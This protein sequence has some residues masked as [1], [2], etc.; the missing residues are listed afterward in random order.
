MGFSIRGYVLEPPRVG[1]SNSPFTSS[2]ANFIS[3]PVAFGIAYP[4]TEA[5]PRADY[6]TLVTN[7][8]VGGLLRN[9]SFGWTKNEVVR[10]FDYASR[11][12]RFKPL[13]G[14]TI[15]TAG[16]I[17]PNSNTQRLK[18]VPAPLQALAD[19]P[20]RLSI[21]TVGSGNTQ[22][23]V[24][25][26]NDG[27][28]GAPPAGTTELSLATGNLNWNP[29]DLVAYDGQ[30]LRY[31]QQAYFDYDKS[32]GD[33]GLIN[34]PVL[35]LNPIP[36]TGQFPLIRI[37]FSLYLTPIERP[38]EAGFSPDPAAGTVE[39]ALN[40]GRLKFHSADIAAHLGFPIYYDGTL[41][42]I[43]LQLP[44]Q[45]IGLIDAPTPIV[46]LPPD[47]GD[48]IFDLPSHVPY[49][50]FAQVVRT[51]TF[52][53]VGKA[54]E[55]QVN[56]GTGAVQFSVSDRAIYTGSPVE[57]V[58]GDLVID[59]GVS[60]RLFRTPVNLDASSTTKDVTTIY[61]VQN[62]VWASP[63]I[64]SPQVFLPS[65]PIDALAYPL[66]VS[67]VQGTGSFTGTLNRLDVPGPPPGLGYF[68]DFDA[69]T[70]HYAQRKNQTLI[71]LLQSS[72]TV[73]LPD[74]L[75]LPGN[76][77]LELETGTGTGIYNPLTIGTDVLL[78]PTPGLATFTTTQGLTIATGATASFSGLTFTDAAG[79][80][81]AAGVQP[82]DFI[83]ISSSAAK[84]VYTVAA[85][86]SPTQLT[87]DVVAQ[88]PS[89]TGPPAPV[90][91]T[92][93]AYT[94]ERGKEILADRFFQEVVLIDPSTMLER[95]RGIGVIQNAT[96]IVA[97]QNATFPDFLTLSDPL[98]NF[99]TSGV[100][101]GDTILLNSGP[102]TGTTRT[103]TFVEQ[104]KLTVASNL[105]FAF[106]T[107]ATYS[108]TRRLRIP[109]SSIGTSRFRFGLNT[110]STSVNPVPNDS[111]FTNPVT[112][113]SGIVE[114]SQVTGNLNFSNA[115]IV[116]ALQIYWIRKLTPRI[117]YKLSPQLGLIQFTDRMLS[118]E[119][120]LVTYT[121]APPVTTPPT[122][123]GPLVQ[124][125]ATFLVR[126][127]QSQPHPT[128]TN[129][130][131]FNPTGRTVADNPPPA[132]FRGGRPQQTGV[133]CNVDLAAFTVTF[134]PDAQVTDV[135]PHGAIIGP[136]ER[137]LVDYFVFE[138]LGGEK[139]T[140]IL[141]PPML[142]ALVN[143]TEGDNFFV[144][145]GDQTTNFP[146]GFL[147]RIEQEEVY[148]IGASSYD[149]GADLTTVTLFGAQTF[150]NSYSDP[151]IFV[152]SGPTRLTSFLFF[153]AYFTPEL[154]AYD[155]V[156]R[157]MNKIFV[158][159]DRTSS[160]RSGVTVYFT[161]G[162]SSFSDFIQVTGAQFH[163][164]TGKT[165]VT[166]AA[167]AL[168]QYMHGPQILQY[169]VR[170]IF[171]EG[172]TTALTSKA[173]VL[174]QPYSL[175]RRAEGEAGILLLAPTDYQIDDAGAVK[176]TPALR[177]KEE[178]SIFYTGH[179][180]VG[181]GPRVR[182]SYTFSI[183]PTAANGLEGQILQANYYVF[184]PDNFYYRVETLTNFKGEVAQEIQA[185]AQAGSPSSGPQ[186]SNSSSPQ[187][188]QQGRE[189][190]FF[191]EGHLAN[192]DLVARGSL[193]FF[194]DAVNYL[195]DALHALDGRVVGGNNGRF[196]FDGNITN[197]VRP[198]PAA[199]TNQIDDKLVVSPFPLPSGTTQA[200]YLQ[201]PYSRFFKN[202]RDLF[203]TS[204]AMVSGST[205]DG[206][207]IAK[208]TFN[209]LSSLP[210]VAFK[211]TPRAQ[212]QFDYPYGT[213]TFTVDNANGTN[214]ALQRPSFVN[215][216]RVVIED[217]QGRF[218]V[219]D[220]DTA[221][222][223]SFTATTVTISVGAHSPTPGP[224][225]GFLPA[226]STIYLSPSDANTSLEKGDYP[227]AAGT[228]GAYMMQYR[229]GHDLDFNL[230]TGEFLFSERS[231]PYNGILSILPPLVRPFGPFFDTF[232]V[233]NGDI[234]QVFGAGLN[235]SAT[236]P[237]KFP[238]LYGGTTNDDRDQALPI[239]GPT[240]DGEL[241][242]A[243]GGPLNVEITAEQPVT[244]TIRLATTAPYLGTGS[245]DVTTTIITDAN[246]SFPA[247][248]P[249]VHD[250]VRILTG[251]NGA[252]EFRRIT[253]VGVNTI[254]VDSPF[255]VQD[256]GFSYTIA[257][258][259]TTVTG[260][261][262][263]A[264][265]T[266]TDALALFT[267]TAQIGW[268]VV[269][270]SGPNI[271]ERRQIVTVVSNTQLTLDSAF[272][273]P[274]IGGTYRIDNPLDTY[275]GPLT[276]L[277][278]ISSAVATELATINTNPNSEQAAL[279]AFLAT[280]F[281]TIVSSVNG[282]VTVLTQLTDITA[283]YI[284]SGV[285]TSHLVYIQTGTNA[286]IY[287][288]ASVDSPTQ[289]TV[290]T[291][292]PVA[293]AGITYQIVSYFGAGLMTFQDIFS[294]LAANETFTTQTLAF[295]AL[296][297]TPVPVLLVTLP[298][299]ASFARGIL[300]VDLDTRTTQ[301]Q[302]RLAYLTNPGTGPIAKIQK[303]LT[304]SDRLYDKR[305]S[306]IDARIN[307][308]T[309]YLVKEQRAV[310]D[311]IKAQADI[312]NQLIKLLTV[313]GS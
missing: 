286:G 35:L 26:L 270:T 108:I 46:G 272:S 221:T 71:P 225:P 33:I 182:A 79:G 312:L 259:S 158:F 81:V 68:I 264:G 130:V 168:R 276:I 313:Q 4:N 239:V 93:A 273:S 229:F 15:V 76:V 85:V 12:G 126:K 144:V 20:F 11:D 55:V 98:T 84:G 244:G 310:A 38:N 296:V 266:L 65:V 2:P 243:G 204:P 180:I 75:V 82:G 217:P 184:S 138:A 247:P 7:E 267:T 107:A 236:A 293:G 104:N 96:V 64:G 171:E 88:T 134:L 118:F 59:H 112:L 52:D 311:R 287:S 103:V 22:T 89:L 39:W 179:R 140:T 226:G 133:Q 164:D 250:L 49:V 242:A 123:A 190:V 51:T 251:L 157:G 13:P 245:L 61:A 189:S 223:S 161:D 252:T 277:A 160:Y 147:M 291:P 176:Y 220:S 99:I 34:A 224:D 150:Q 30:V 170:P 302:T 163:A 95:I 169:T 90:S 127:E 215:Q 129:T 48:I 281:T 53:A 32:T 205:G 295:Q 143:I 309:G 25:V 137:V 174:T 124:E 67:V 23:V 181:A 222:V 207:A 29:S 151:K 285:N 113:L 246:P 21:G 145:H 37:G 102:D 210:T 212:I 308:E 185:A 257:V 213:T 62:A 45:S 97:T 283:N 136:S 16:P 44:R 86:V 132:V 60:I 193:K 3:D 40:T 255:V 58:F 202:L 121:P 177:P 290:Q 304:G 69:R 228:N 192:Q 288:I 299:P 167:N 154:Q 120:V 57:V 166:L 289:I 141:Q 211:R 135:I 233:Q 209:N 87:T 303:A 199:V 307:Q 153:P 77:V 119:E 105:P 74:P 218:F 146:A 173:P 274:V 28:F 271:A 92:N 5:N 200:I 152:S 269:M 54:N 9:A 142:T 165:E 6:L 262:T 214:D 159:G 297:N 14:G 109:I 306:W 268:T 194:N 110:L 10:R 162:T 122:P 249:Q 230:S 253:V 282:S 155:P 101:V 292:F 100:Q 187:L 18:A 231:F 301:A 195:E 178:V 175:F 19:A 116:P 261:A 256:A 260:T 1:Q 63:I 148:L 227:P 78:D 70:F 232:P 237:D 24:L 234:L 43:A 241:T 31:Q 94:I 203:A 263:L 258:S 80:F 50:Q 156:A 294:I 196:L 131:S 149:V 17:G 198:N 275:G 201:G 248:L 254:T 73:A 298:D 238:A 240:F 278:A 300:T 117:D 128:P 186:T 36:G 305:Y 197:P 111:S 280:I 208:A 27:A 235:I 56:P 216:M 219:L 115:D 183:A 72:G 8:G 188:F 206:D 83:V 66:T 42:A 41:F 172:T 106:L 191:P 139:T 47:G 91:V 265:T 125:R 284:T 279:L 114:V